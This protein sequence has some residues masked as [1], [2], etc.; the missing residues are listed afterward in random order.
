[1]FIKVGFE[2]ALFIR[3]VEIRVFESIEK[4]FLDR[5]LSPKQMKCEKSV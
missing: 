3:S 5:K 4:N 1:M 2:T